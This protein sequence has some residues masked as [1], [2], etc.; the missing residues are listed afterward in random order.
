MTSSNIILNAKICFNVLHHFIQKINYRRHFDH[1]RANSSCLEE[2]LIWHPIIVR[3]KML[4]AFYF[5]AELM[6]A[7]NLFRRILFVRLEL[8][9]FLLMEMLIS[10]RKS[11]MFMIIIS[12]AVSKRLY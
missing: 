5:A 8:N 7:A 11:D 6:N 2:N 4:L 3:T 1:I 9:R 10:Q 12:H